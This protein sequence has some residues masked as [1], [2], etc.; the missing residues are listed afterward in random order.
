MG[1]S[2]RCGVGPVLADPNN[3][4]GAL[5][6]DGADFCAVCHVLPLDKV[7]RRHRLSQ[8]GLNPDLADEYKR[9]R[10]AHIHRAY[11]ERYGPRP[12]LR[13]HEP[14]PND[15]GCAG[16]EPGADPRRSRTESQ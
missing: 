16:L 12:Q 1:H 8:H 9:S 4:C 5:E 15:I 2:L 3:V 11:T 7:W 14:I 10:D 13:S 6:Y